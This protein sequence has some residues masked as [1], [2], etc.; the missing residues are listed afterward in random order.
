MA[1]ENSIQNFVHKLEEGG[2][3]RWIQIILLLAAF[4]GV[5]VKLIFFDFRGLSDA[6]GM[7][8][9]QISREVTKGHGFSTRFIRPLAIRQ[10]RENLDDFPEPHVPDTYHAPLGPVVNALPL[11]L[12]GSLKAISRDQSNYRPDQMIVALAL[13]FFLLG[14]WLNFL[15]LRR[16]FDPRIAWIVAGLMLV[17]A[18]F[19]EL[20]QT[21]LP[22]MLMFALFGGCALT[23]V[24]ALEAYHGGCG[25][26]W[27]LAACA[28][29]FGLLALA[30]AL[31]IWL[32]VG[33]LIF[34]AVAFRP[35]GRD[36]GIM[37]ALFLVI[38][39]P[40]L[41][42]TYSVSGSP[43][44]L[45]GY[46]LMAGAAVEESAMMRDLD[47]TPSVSIGSLRRKVQS[48]L[49]LQLSNL[50]GNLGRCVAA[51]IFFLALLHAFKRPDT[52]VLLWGVLLMFVCGVLGMAVFGLGAGSSNANN[53]YPLLLP[54]MAGYGM[55]FLFVLWGR[56]GLQGRILRSA[57][58]GLVIVLSALPFVGQLLGGGPRFYWPPYA[59]PVLGVVSGW[60]TDD[61]VVAS[62]Q[63]WA[64]AWYADRRSIWIPLKI[65]NFVDMVDYRR[66]GPVVGLYMTPVSGDAR[67]IRD[68][69]LGE[70]KEWAPLVTKTID[71]AKF[72]LPAVVPLW[73]D[74]EILYFSDRVRWEKGAQ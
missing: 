47:K 62:D 34:V 21:G 59:P 51:P 70:Y 29:L 60:T 23:L 46:T 16:L 40:W 72:V 36:A 50:Y 48:Q 37:A 69:Q 32:F 25:P 67:F 1:T 26:T 52:R 11:W 39:A 65:Q 57:F 35:R 22:Q 13:L 7:D 49:G 15:A 42:R 18:D 6:K 33:V 45:A 58:I 3:A 71:P 27:W 44:G 73:S 20:A 4:G 53:L 68:I 2:W 41:V 54:L 31:T 28:V 66:Y 55:A 38:Y 61:E 64:V 19:Y 30:H 24:R 63:P 56:L 14:V 12:T 10:F 17:C 43:F 9:A 74:A 5:S 8:Q